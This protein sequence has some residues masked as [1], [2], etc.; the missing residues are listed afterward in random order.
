MAEFNQVTP[1]DRWLKPIPAGG[2]N[3]QSGLNFK[4][5]QELKS[6]V[7]RDLL[8]KWTWKE[9]PRCAMNAPARRPWP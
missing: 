2:E 6:S 8:K 3:R 5:Y 9:W 1:S 7:H 4:V